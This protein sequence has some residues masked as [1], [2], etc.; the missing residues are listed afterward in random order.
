MMKK[1]VL[2][3]MLI[4][5]FIFTA[6][7]KIELTEVKASNLIDLGDYVQIGR[8][9][10]EA[11]IWRCVDI[12]ENGPLMLADR[13]LTIKP[14]DVSGTHKY[15][16][17]TL[18]PDNNNYRTNYGSN[19][20]ET[21][22]I[23]SWLNSTATAGSVSWLDE[24]PP[25]QSAVYNGL[26]DYATEKG[27]MADGNF[28][29][30][31]RNAI[32][33]VIQKS[34]LNGI[35]ASKLKVGGT[36]THAFNS[37]I[38]TIVQN[39][40]NA[41]YQNVTDKMFLLDVKQINKVYQNSYILGANYY[42]GKPTQK[43]IDYS[44]YK[45]SELR[46]NNYWGNWIRTPF[47]NSDNPYYVRFVSNIGTVSY[48]D[49]NKGELGTRPAFYIDLLSLSFTSGNGLEAS[50]FIVDNGEPPTPTPVSSTPTPIPLTPTPVP[51]TPTPTSPTPT[52]EATQLPG[53]S[54]L[55]SISNMSG[56]PGG[57][58]TVTI[59]L[60]NNYNPK[61]ISI[62]GYLEYDQN[63]LELVRKDEY[64]P[65]LNKIVPDVLQVKKGNA[66]YSTVKPIINPDGVRGDKYIVSMYAS[67]SQR[68]LVTTAIPTVR[69][70][71][72]V[73][74]RIIS[75]ALPGNI[76]IKWTVASLVNEDYESQVSR[77]NSI[78]DSSIN[79][80][81][82]TLTP[83]PT[84]TP[85]PPTPTLAPTTPSPLPDRTMDFTISKNMDVVKSGDILTLTVGTKDWIGVVNGIS[86]L[87]IKL[88]FDKNYFEYIDTSITQESEISIETDAFTVSTQ[89]QGII[90]I[91]YMDGNGQSPIPI[92]CDLFNIRFR[93]KSVAQT[94]NHGF[95][96]YGDNEVTDG[97]L[98]NYN[99]VAVS[100]P[101]IG[102]V[103]I[104]N[105][106]PKIPNDL[107]VLS[108]T[109]SSV[110]LL[111]TPV[112]DAS[113]YNIYCGAAKVNSL[114]VYSSNYTVSDLLCNN[115]YSFSVKGTNTVGESSASTVINITT[116]PLIKGDI[117]GDVNI[118][119]IDLVK[120]KQHLLRI[121]ILGTVPTTAGDLNN[122][123]GVTISDLLAML[124][125]L[126]GIELIS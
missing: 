65:V 90:A 81:M 17:A 59:S 107:M 84:P 39:N 32:K 105:T 3:I 96:L 44:E 28:T 60:I 110:N 115:D 117:D 51:P 108:K 111:W 102:N 112:E 52:P 8:Y 71:Y 76:P 12:D 9:N 80:T 38:A 69:T 19:L 68:V 74:F 26:N 16:D 89:N 11:I 70:L 61:I 95:T 13:I 97:Q 42:I 85:V 72:T 125:H 103:Y 29:S 6:F 91:L 123:G 35:D 30:T 106:V 62:F 50:P 122:D 77:C 20:W 116:N 10:D 63:K 24:C 124:K 33:S 18:Q 118:S 5:S 82:S 104:T 83:T 47:A 73:T 43:A 99:I 94:G 23:R 2:S 21:S 120:I 86:G 45:N 36:S 27:F 40:D 25:T 49:A 46:T 101:D 93:V 1:R 22:N 79:V 15:L 55:F 54:G 34:I 113:G 88:G 48:C 114:P 87:M 7:P 41:Y 37:D 4:T 31:E 100:F 109:Y 64:D 119:I 57:E 58:V 14:F 92:E 67:A 121:S 75:D 66:F 78:V 126:L 53:N 98:P 56:N